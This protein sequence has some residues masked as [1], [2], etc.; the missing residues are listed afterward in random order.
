MLRTTPISVALVGLALAGCSSEALKATD[1]AA[2]AG[3]PATGEGSE[4]RR[5]PYPEGPY[6]RGVG[7][8][9]ANLSFLGWRDPGAA[10]YDP[11]RLEKV[12]LSDFYN[13]GG[14]ESDVR[15]LLLNASA[16]WC[17]VCRSEYRHIRTAD[18][19]STYRPQG[20]EML[21]VLFEDVNYNP[22]KPSDLVVWGGPDGYQLPFGLVLD[23]GFKTGVYF[24]SDATPM[25]MLIDTTT[26]QIIDVT[27]GYNATSPDEY[28]EQ[29]GA[30][31][32]Q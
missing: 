1:G 12:E 11:S 10:A 15:L 6:G 14:S 9:I 2:D 13:P 26:M 24:E 18:V 28:W 23:P 30:L 27:M 29:I 4:A 7:A 19:Y 17:S 32:R 3:E 25:N 16:V 21:G 31:L 22:A 8:T 20:L 5:A